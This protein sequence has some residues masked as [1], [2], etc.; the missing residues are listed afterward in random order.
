MRVRKTWTTKLA[1]KGGAI[2]STA[3]MGWQ[4]TLMTAF[5]QPEQKRQSISPANVLPVPYAR[6]TEPRPLGD[7]R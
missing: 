3:H 1:S 6:K 2:N 4:E 5:G 7:Q